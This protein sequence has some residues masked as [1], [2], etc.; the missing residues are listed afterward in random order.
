MKYKVNLYSYRNF[1]LA[2]TVILSLAGCDY[3]SDN[4]EP[5]NEGCKSS[6]TDNKSIATIV[7]GEIN[8]IRMEKGCP[9]E[10]DFMGTNLVDIT[11]NDA[12][13]AAT[14]V[15]ND[16]T[17]DRM[18]TIVGI[19]ERI[20]YKEPGNASHELF[21]RAI[22]EFTAFMGAKVKIEGQSY[23]FNKG[24]FTQACQAALPKASSDNAKPAKSFFS[25]LFNWSDKTEE[26]QSANVQAMPEPDDAQARLMKAAGYEFKGGE[27]QKKP[28]TQATTGLSDEE[29]GFSGTDAFRKRKMA[30]EAAED[31]EKRDAGSKSDSARSDVS[32]P[33][34]VANN[35]VPE[36]KQPVAYPV[37]ANCKL[38]NGKYIYAY[39]S[40]D[41]RS[42][43]Y[44]YLDKNEKQELELKDGLF[45]VTAFHYHSSF[46]MGSADYLRFNKGVYD[47]L[48][49]NKDNGK[50]NEFYGLQVYKDG[51]RIFSHECTEKMDMDFSA[52]PNNSRRDSDDKADYF[53]YQ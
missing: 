32:Q 36:E 28:H 14:L 29:A 3:F 20:P 30:R 9:D 33:T 44:A 25:K 46:G 10:L 43:N 53:I 51:K 37:N 8:F 26:K 18:V 19:P 35:P 27:W 21:P 38:D 17:N 23:R 47:Y 7:N 6:S 49:I 40:P 15:C 39:A 16:A 1:A 12:R 41:G 48:I 50:D 31:A 42:Y 52:Y 5:K 13:Y 45:G 11:I 22:K 2:T 24:N 4:W 34:P